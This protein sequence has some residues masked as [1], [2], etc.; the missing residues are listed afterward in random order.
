MLKRFRIVLLAL[1]A[2]ATLVAA[3]APTATAAN[4]RL[5]RSRSTS[6]STTSTRR[7]LAARSCSRTC[8]GRSSGTCTSKATAALTGRSRRSKA[9]SRGSYG[10][11]TNVLVPDLDQDR[12]RLP[13]RR[14]LF[15]P[16]RITLTGT[17]GGVFPIFDG[18][19][20]SGELVYDG[21]MYSQ[22]W[23][24]GFVYWANEGP[25]LSRS[26]DFDQATQRICDALA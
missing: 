25:P 8:R 11:A 2:V 1:A 23:D 9:G 15:N 24:T 5:T 10:T 26:G 22:D 17:N 12:D 6:R 7:P 20:G 16:V 21:F 14:R 19:A 18:P 3:A 4:L 13:E